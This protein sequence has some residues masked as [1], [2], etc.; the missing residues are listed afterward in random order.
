MFQKAIK[1]FKLSHQ[2]KQNTQNID[3]INFTEHVYQGI[4]LHDVLLRHNESIRPSFEGIA[5]KNDLL[6]ILDKQEE[7][8][9][10]VS[11]EGPWLGPMSI[12]NI[13]KYVQADARPWP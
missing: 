8:A 6:Y 4:A 11:Y 13:A 2:N 9:Q 3:P 12:W 1:M 7:M 10:Y 5:E